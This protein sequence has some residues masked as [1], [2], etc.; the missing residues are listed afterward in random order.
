MLRERLRGLLG[1]HGARSLRFDADRHAL[2]GY[3][4][5]HDP[6]SYNWPGHHRGDPASASVI[7]QYAL[8]GWGAF[9]S[10]GITRRVPAGSMFAAVMPSAHR[11]YLPGES[12]GWTFFWIIVRQPYVVER[13]RDRLAS[14]GPVLATP[15]DGKVVGKLLSLVERVVRG[16][17]DDG[18]AFEVALFDA[19][20]EW[21]RACEQTKYPQSPRERLLNKVRLEVERRLGEPIEV[22]SLAAGQSMSRSAFTHHFTATTGLS[23]ARFVTEIKLQEV[24]ERLRNSD[25]K[26][27]AIATAC[28]FADANHLC[29]AFKRHYA[30]TPAR[31]RQQ[32]R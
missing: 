23:P 5:R 18:L 2:V 8:D 7:F 30:T 28:G 1:E 4:T 26:L 15:P 32:F 31:Y 27:A 25:Q 13:V 21:E 20:V 12:T 10:D 19:V 24:A 6:R 17:F 14:S 22:E 16:G 29:K 11:Y 3:E 9:E